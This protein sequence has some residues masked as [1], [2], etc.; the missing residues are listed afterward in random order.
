M[1]WYMRGGLSIHEAYSLGIDDME[2]FNKIIE[3]NIEASKKAQMP[4]L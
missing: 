1:C 3:D 4:L 2:I